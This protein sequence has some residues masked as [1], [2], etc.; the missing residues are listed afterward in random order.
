MRW[1]SPRKG[2]LVSVVWI[3]LYPSL[4]CLFSVWSDATVVARV[5]AFLDRENPPPTLLQLLRGEIERHPALS[6]ERLTD[7]RQLCLDSVHNLFIASELRCLV[8]PR[9]S[10]VWYGVH[11]VT[12]TRLRPDGLLVHPVP[13]SHPTEPIAPSPIGYQS[14]R[15][16]PT[17]PTRTPI[18]FGRPPS[19]SDVPSSGESRLPTSETLLRTHS[20]G[21]AG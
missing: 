1:R 21:T 13:A 6:S 9:E 16:D 3:P 15:M 14:T 2:R 19:V 12:V 4:Q 7:P 11:C 5:T 17:P 18:R 10:R 20:N 8:R